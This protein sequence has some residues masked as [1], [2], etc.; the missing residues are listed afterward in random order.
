MQQA[1]HI[2]ILRKS[3]KGRHTRVRVTPPWVKNIANVWLSNTNMGNFKVPVVKLD[4]FH[5]PITHAYTNYIVCPEV[6][7][8]HPAS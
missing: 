7:P 2:A 6:L 8:N 4:P 1:P 3:G 5:V